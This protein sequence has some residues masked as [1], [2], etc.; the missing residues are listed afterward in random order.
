MEGNS[1]KIIRVVTFGSEVTGSFCFLLAFIVRVFIYELHLYFLY[2]FK[3]LHSE[4]SR[5]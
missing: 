3:A 5:L 4:L 1:L 2:R